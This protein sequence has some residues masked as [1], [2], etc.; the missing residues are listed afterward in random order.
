MAV[1]SKRDVL[2]TLVS[3]SELFEKKKKLM[4]RNVLYRLGNLYGQREADGVLRDEIIK[5]EWAAPGSGSR[6]NTKGRIRRTPT[7]V[8]ITT[9]NDPQM[10]TRCSTSGSALYSQIALV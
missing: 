6:K 1:Y 2:Y 3:V 4:F 7:R 5:R 10:L 9:E 8:K